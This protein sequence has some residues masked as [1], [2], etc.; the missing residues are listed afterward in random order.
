MHGAKQ[1]G[2]HFSSR[3]KRPGPQNRGRGR[4]P[5]NRTGRA[6]TDEHRTQACACACATF[7]VRRPWVDPPCCFSPSPSHMLLEPHTHTHGRLTHTPNCTRCLHVE[8]SPAERSTE[9]VGL[10]AA[11]GHESTHWERE[12]RCLGGGR[13]RRG[14]RAAYHRERILRVGEN[15]R[16]DLDG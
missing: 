12:T 5:G 1:R 16:H 2:A 10:R 3:L 13:R 4:E 14:Q 15:G 11:Q 8:A 7:S 9:F 6:T